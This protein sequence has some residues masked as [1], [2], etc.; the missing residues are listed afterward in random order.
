LTES[1]TTTVRVWDVPTRLFHWLLA[2]LVATNVVTGKF[3]SVLGADAILWHARAGYAILGLLV[4]RVAWGFAGSTYARFAS[5]L[6]GPSA[7]LAYA[8]GLLARRGSGPE[9]LGHNPLGGW[10]IM[11]MLA[12]LATQAATGLFI[13]Q[14]DYA[15]E[16]PLAK[17]VSGAVCDRMNAIHAVNSWVIVALVALHL[18]AIGFYALV[19]RERL[20]AAMV[21]GNKRVTAVGEDAAARGGGLMA[22]VALA[23]AS[24]ATVWALVTL[25]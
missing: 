12:S 21:T 8:K 24:A 7:A 14:E 6:R 3:D 19:K 20:V 22:G 25:A 11:A 10:W 18:S 4:F 2:L 17:H 16:G 23:A 9:P 1:V 13:V 5:F 15:F